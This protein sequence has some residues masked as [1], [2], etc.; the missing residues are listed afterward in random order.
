LILSNSAIFRKA[1]AKAKSDTAFGFD[2]RSPQRRQV[3]H[4]FGA[5]LDRE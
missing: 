1:G 2:T 3:S 5:F 4:R